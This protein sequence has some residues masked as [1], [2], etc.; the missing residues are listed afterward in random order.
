MAVIPFPPPPP[1]TST[2]LFDITQGQSLYTQMP[3]EYDRIVCLSVQGQEGAGKTDFSFS[4][5]DPIAYINFDGANWKRVRLRYPDKDI[6]IVTI[7]LPEQPKDAN[8]EYL[9]NMFAPYYQQYKNAM[10]GA[11]ADPEIRSVVVDTKTMAWQLARLA[12]LGKLK[13]VKAQHYDEVNA[14]FRRVIRMHDKFNKC[15]VFIHREKEEYIDNNKTGRYERDG[16]KEIPN[17]VQDL[18]RCGINNENKFYVEVLRSK[19]RPQI[20]GQV[21]IQPSNTFVDL[22][23]ALW[24]DSLPTDWM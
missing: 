19:T 2:K 7:E 18:V 21:Y 17:E 24:P 1:L 20:N 4:L 16:F 3:T 8:P 14:D 10:L 23:M 22:A 15:V 12:N 5:P 9:Q 11:L 6:R 13:S